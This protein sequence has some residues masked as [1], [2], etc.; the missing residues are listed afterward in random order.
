MD[1]GLIYNSTEHLVTHSTFS[2]HTLHCKPLTGQFHACRH[3]PLTD[4]VPPGGLV[5]N[6]GVFENSR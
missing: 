3:V 5:G 1:L 4:I 2:G 6:N